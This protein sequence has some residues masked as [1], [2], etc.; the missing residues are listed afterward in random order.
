MQTPLT[1][2]LGWLLICQLLSLTNVLMNCQCDSW[3][4]VLVA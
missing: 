4:F 1:R 2:L 3:G